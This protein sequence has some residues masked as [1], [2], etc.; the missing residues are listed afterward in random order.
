MWVIYLVTDDQCLT[1]ITFLFLCTRQQFVSTRQ[2]LLNISGPIPG[3]TIFSEMSV[4]LLEE[5]L[6]SPSESTTLYL[7]S[8]TDDISLPRAISVKKP[9]ITSYTPYYDLGV[10]AWHWETR[11]F[12]GSLAV[13]WRASRCWKKTVAI[14]VQRDLVQLTSWTLQSTVF[15]CLTSNTLYW[16]KRIT[17]EVSS[18]LGSYACQLLKSYRSFEGT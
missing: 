13:W 11:T 6:C 1:G 15:A 7:R 17:F 16:T 18:L 10:E 9:S 3:R 2:C 4:Q 12:S 14:S 5:T 8:V